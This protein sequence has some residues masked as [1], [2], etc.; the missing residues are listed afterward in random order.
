MTPISTNVNQGFAQGVMGLYII[1]YFAIWVMGLILQIFIK[2]RMK[3]M[4]K[5]GGSGTSL[6]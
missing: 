5:Q 4:V 1:V 6:Y 2:R 3:A